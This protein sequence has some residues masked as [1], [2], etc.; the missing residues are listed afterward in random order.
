MRCP[1][2]AYLLLESNEILPPERE[3]ERQ[4]SCSNPWHPKHPGA[5]PACKEV[6][7]PRGLGIGSSVKAEFEYCGH[8]WQPQFPA[9]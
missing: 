4:R 8:R 1:E 9:T 7:F 6:G 5:C 3:S 2:D